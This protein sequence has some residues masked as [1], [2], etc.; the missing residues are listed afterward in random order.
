MINRENWKLTRRYLAYRQARVSKRTVLTDK[1]GLKHMLEWAD[2]VSFF[3]ADQLQP[4]PAY[5]VDG[6]GFSYVYQMRVGYVAIKFVEWLRSSQPKRSSRLND[7]WAKSLL[8]RRQDD[9]VGNMD[10]YTID[11]IRQL[12]AVPAPGLITART[13]AAV[14]MLFLSGMRSGAFVTLPIECVDLALG[15]IWQWPDRGVDTKNRKRA[16]T[17]LLNIPDLLDV[18][19]RWDDMIRPVLPP[20]D[21]WYAYVA[22]DGTAITGGVASRNRGPGLAC[23][24]R[25]LCDLAGV[26]YRRPHDIRH[27]HATYAITQC[28]DMATYKAISINLMHGSIT[29]T[30]QVYVN[31]AAAD[32]KRRVES[33]GG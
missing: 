8:P 27:G 3:R 15:E 14:A 22:K 24:L 13:Q 17:F 21:A 9:T 30:D 11:E 4:L 2:S 28:N 19:R 1:S 20:W 18:A 10:P 32:V 29:I 25:R 7:L 5:L 16:T 26:R 33:I 31:M 23:D 12:C 6:F